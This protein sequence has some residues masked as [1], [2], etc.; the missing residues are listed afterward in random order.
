MNKKLLYHIILFVILSLWVSSVKGQCT[1][2]IPYSSGATYQ[3]AQGQS[4]KA[5]CSGTLNKVGFYTSSNTSS[6]LTLSIYSGNSVSAGDILGSVSGQSLGISSAASDF[7]FIDVSSENISITSGDT[8]TVYFSA[9]SPYPTINVDNSNPYSDGNYWNSATSYSGFDLRMEVDISAVLPVE[10]VFF[11]GQL[12]EDNIKLNW[13]TATE[14]NNFGFEIERC[15]T[16]DVRSETWEKIGFLN[17]HGN[18][19]SPKTY[20]FVDANPPIGKVFYRLK[21]IDFDG[22]YEYSDVVEV[23]NNSTYYFELSQNYPNPFNPSTVISFS[24][25]ETAKAKLIIFDMLGREIGELINKEL[26][27]GNHKI[28]FDGSNLTSGIYFYRLETANYNQTRKFIL[29]K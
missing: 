14:V 11:T 25:P 7:Q 20:Y 3:A 4:F 15:E 21:Q 8:Y 24:L 17:G 6:G 12:N 13:K 1:V 28:Y 29:M 18:S 26:A 9:G 2:T 27:A 23:I 19:H 10:L 22:A 5:T 16:Q